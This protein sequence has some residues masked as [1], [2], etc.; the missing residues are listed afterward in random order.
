[1]VGHLARDLLREHGLLDDKVLLIHGPFRDRRVLINDQG[2]LHAFE[3]EHRARALAG[4]DHAAFLITLAEHLD[5]LPGRDLKLELGLLLD[6][7]QLF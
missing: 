3:R 7:D 5:L 2:V 4:A 6:R 1:M